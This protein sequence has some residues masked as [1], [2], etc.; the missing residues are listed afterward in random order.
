MGDIADAWLFGSL[1]ELVEFEERMRAVTVADIQAVAA[2]WLH[3]SR[4]V[5]GAVR[6][7]IG[8]SV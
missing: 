1:D 8:R 3:A 4:R 2:E 7:E 5:E 6:G